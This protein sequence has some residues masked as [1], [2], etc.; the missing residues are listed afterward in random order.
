MSQ[1]NPYAAPRSSVG[2]VGG[3]GISEEILS[4]LRQT[5][6]WVRLF[7]ALGFISIIFMVLGSLGM[8]IGGLMLSGGS[9]DGGPAVMVML[10]GGIVYLLFGLLY[11][12]PT[13]YL[14]QY[15]S[16]I[17]RVLSSND[18]EDLE[19]A[20]YRQKAFWK[21]IGIMAVIIFIL[22][23]VAAIAVPFLGMAMN[24]GE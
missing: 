14:W 21:F 11:F 17:A 7:S 1:S 3:G 12:F 13:L 2:S 19:D 9:E 10:A 8:I 22:G 15:A 24:V 16:A 23:I 4:S 5:K 20:L 6:P 18:M